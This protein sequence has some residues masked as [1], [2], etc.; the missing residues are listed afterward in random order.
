MFLKII[1]NII[2]KFDALLIQIYVNK[3]IGQQ[4]RTMYFQ[5]DKQS[6]YNIMKFTIQEQKKL[7]VSIF[8]HTDMFQE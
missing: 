5:S 4:Y 8:N 1:K 2:I 6:I 7:N 3:R